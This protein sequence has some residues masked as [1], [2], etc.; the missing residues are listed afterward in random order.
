MPLDGNVWTVMKMSLGSKVGLEIQA[1]H[2]GW[3]FERYVFHC[4]DSYL[5]FSV[6]HLFNILFFICIL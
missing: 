5:H 4:Q 6:L 2:C 1:S 3:R